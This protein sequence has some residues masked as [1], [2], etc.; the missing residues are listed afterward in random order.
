VDTAGVS[1]V[2]DIVNPHINDSDE[3]TIPDEGTDDEQVWDDTIPRKKPSK[4]M[5]LKPQ[6][7]KQYKRKLSP[8]LYVHLVSSQSSAGGRLR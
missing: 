7:P 3:S 8:L 5:V 2:H 6:V 4:P 1:N